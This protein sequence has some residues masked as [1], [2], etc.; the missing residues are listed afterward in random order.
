MAHV[1]ARGLSIP[2]KPGQCRGFQ[3][4]RVSGLRLYAAQDRLGI[5]FATSVQLFQGIFAICTAWTFSAHQ[6]IEASDQR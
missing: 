4:S 6:E 2:G 5:R 1:Q 3:V